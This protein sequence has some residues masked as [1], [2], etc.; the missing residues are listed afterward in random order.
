MKGQPLANF[1]ANLMFAFVGYE[2]E[3][4]VCI[5]G[6]FVFLFFNGR[7]SR[8]RRYFDD[9]ELNLQ[10]TAKRAIGYLITLSQAEE[11]KI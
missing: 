9:P 1:F 6:C 5:G 11:V 2:R 7:S 8:G 3:V 10:Q 4:G